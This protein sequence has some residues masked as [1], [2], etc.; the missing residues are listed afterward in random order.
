AALTWTPATASATAHP[1]SPSSTFQAAYLDSDRCR[2]LAE[3]IAHIGTTRPPDTKFAAA[4]AQGLQ[5]CRSGDF[6]DGADSLAEAVRM[7]G[8]T[9]AVPRPTVRLH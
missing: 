2:V 3:Q 9:P 7:T 1:G 5:L 8:E 4:V 6:A